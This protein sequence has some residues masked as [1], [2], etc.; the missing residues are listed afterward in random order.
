M[1][2][3]FCFFSNFLF[4]ALPQISRHPI[5][6]THCYPTAQRGMGLIAYSLYIVQSITTH[7]QVD[8][9]TSTAPR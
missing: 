3:Y 2:P 8:L 7:Y 1:F 5:C 9:T 4:I 6:P